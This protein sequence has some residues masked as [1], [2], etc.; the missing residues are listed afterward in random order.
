MVSDPQY[1]AASSLPYRVLKLVVCPA[2]REVLHQR[3]RE[4]FGTMMQQGFLDEM[5]MLYN[6]SDLFEDL[7]SSRA[8]GYRQG[9]DFLAGHQ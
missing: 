8:V 3:I 4:R 2:R 7:P 6:R 5:Q 9:W 1:Q